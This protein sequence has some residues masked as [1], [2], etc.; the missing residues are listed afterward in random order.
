VEH[1]TFSINADYIRKIDYSATSETS[2]GNAVKPAK[3]KAK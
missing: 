3:K 1:K 2:E